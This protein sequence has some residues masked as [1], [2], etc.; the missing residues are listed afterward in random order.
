SRAKDV[1]TKRELYRERWITVLL[2]LA[3]FAVCFALGPWHALCLVVIPMAIS[4][5]TLMMYIATNHWLR[6]MTEHNNP[7]VNTTSVICPRWLDWLHVA[8]SFHQEHH[9]F[10]KMSPRYA[11]LLREEMRKL[12]PGAISAYPLGMTLKMLFVAPSLYLDD[13]TLVGR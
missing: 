13:H 9:V 8:F 10:P 4:N 12:A 1:S 2:I 6:P 5:A 3:W 7:F 11:P